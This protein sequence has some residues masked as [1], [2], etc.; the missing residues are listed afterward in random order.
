M[1]LTHFSRREFL[2]A[3]GAL[4]VSVMVPGTVDTARAQTSGVIGGKPPLSPDELDSWVAVLPD[5]GVTA[6]FGKMD[7]GQ[8]VDVAIGQ[9]V[10]DE[11]D[12]GFE[13]VTVVMGDTAFTCNQGG[14][15]GSTGVQRGGLTLRHAA[16]EARRLLLERAS[17][18]LAV[19]VDRLIVQDG[20]VSVAGDAQRQV[21]YADL[22]GGRYFHHK[23]DWNKQY[24]NPLLAKG[25]A[26]VKK[27]SEY[28]LVGQSIPQKI[29]AE[30]VYGRLQY[31]TEVKVEGMLHARVLRPPSAGC[32]PVAID[33]SSIAGIPGVRVIREKDMVAVLA[34]H[35]WDAVRAARELKV[36]WAPPCAPFPEMTNLYDHIR[37]A[38]ATG[39]QVPVKKGD[40]EAAFTTAQ[41][42]VEAE[43][44]WPFQSHAS[45]G[46]A[47][48]VADVR[49]DQATLWTG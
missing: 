24:G 48:A 40:V 17:A 15:S 11:L 18:K 27:A 13:R 41:R 23:L 3:G 34:E 25:Q 29:V 16:A 21:S 5:G 10:A 47:C 30:K 26:A 39:A 44:E 33:E 36:T 37:Q 46:P 35:E 2:K 14:A 8:G 45:M 42:M 31:V 38:K 20:V 4:V 12:V 19:P 22:I 1:N 32:G 28:R 43:Y 7:M 49:A 6:F 9:I